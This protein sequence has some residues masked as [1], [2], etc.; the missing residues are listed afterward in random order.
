MKCR[1]RDPPDQIERLSDTGI[2]AEFDRTISSCCLQSS[3]SSKDAEERF[4]AAFE[5][6]RKLLMAPSMRVAWSPSWFRQNSEVLTDAIR[7]RDRAWCE[8]V[9]C[10]VSGD[11]GDP[12]CRV[13]YA[14]ARASI[15]DNRH[16]L[17]L[18]VS[19]AS[20]G[21]VDRISGDMLSI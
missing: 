3:E 2:R 15:S 6:A 11:S 14:H 7:A 20:N 8:Y 21:S 12:M 5:E 1:S 9:N 16:C 17:K 4:R 10:A 18:A 13:S 19:Q